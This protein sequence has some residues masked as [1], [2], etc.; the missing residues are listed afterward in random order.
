MKKFLLLLSLA[1]LTSSAAIYTTSTPY[2]DVYI[3]NSKN[4]KKYHYSKS[5]RGLSA[6]KA[7]IKELS[8]AD[9]K[10]IGKTICGWED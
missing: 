4:G 8:L 1:T 5:C 7:T 2:Q 6:C 9:A 10:K 3:C